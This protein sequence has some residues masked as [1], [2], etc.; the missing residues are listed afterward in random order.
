MVNEE[1]MKKEYPKKLSEQ[2]K[3]LK[4][5]KEYFLGFGKFTEPY[6]DKVVAQIAKE[7]SIH[8]IWK[9]IHARFKPVKVDTN[10]YF[11]VKFM[12]DNL[13]VGGCSEYAFLTAAIFRKKG[14]PAAIIDFLGVESLYDSPS[15]DRPIMVEHS[16]VLVYIDGRWYLYDSTDGTFTRF[17]VPRMLKKGFIPGNIYRD[18]IEVGIKNRK[19]KFLKLI[20]NLKDILLWDIS[21]DILEQDFVR[22]Y[23]KHLG[24]KV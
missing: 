5:N 10:Y 7:V 9:E 14:Y 1:V 19:D 20:D 8:S 22:K 15:K 18:P 16:A 3:Y 24:M 23:F 2:I 12:E 17:I 13:V 11:S 21:L 6:E 4:E